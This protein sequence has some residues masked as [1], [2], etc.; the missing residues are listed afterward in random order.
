MGLIEDAEFRVG[1]TELAP[2]ELM[3]VYSD[4]VTD[5]QNPHGEM[6]SREKLLSLFNQPFDNA[7]SLVDRIVS[8]VSSFRGDAIQFDDMT[9]MAVM[10]KG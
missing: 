9:L 5:V 10:R 4:G 7:Q 2:G 6:Y 3:L 1:N 8:E